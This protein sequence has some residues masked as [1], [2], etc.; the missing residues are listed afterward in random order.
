M[1][2]SLGEKRKA[3]STEQIEEITRLYGTFVENERVKIFRNERFGYQRIT[4]DQP[5]RLRYTGKGAQ[6][7][8]E[9][10]KAF[11]KLNDAQRASLLAVIGALTELATTDRADALN[12]AAA[13]NGQLSRPEEKALVEVLAM[14]DPDAPALDEPDPELR[15]QESVPL[16]DESITFE[17]DP[18]ARLASEAYRRA[19]DEYVASEVL[20]YVAEARIDH[21]KTKI[22][23]EIPLTRHFY[24]YAPPRP[25]K[26]IDAEIRALEKE[27]Q[28]LLGEVAR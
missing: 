26:E 18:T 23:Y 8:L 19:I 14:R 27:I 28:E 12:A 22:G 16:P 17:P 7:R 9:A 2:K 24:K 25:L 20:P 13:V 5:L 3:I 4:V 21:A 6:D 15:D 1:R 11:A 10:S